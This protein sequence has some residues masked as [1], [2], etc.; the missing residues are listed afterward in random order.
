LK[1]LKRA[2]LTFSLRERMCERSAAS[3]TCPSRPELTISALVSAAARHGFG[4]GRFQG[5][6]WYGWSYI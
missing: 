1:A 5:L 4:K 3:W 2:P 6:R